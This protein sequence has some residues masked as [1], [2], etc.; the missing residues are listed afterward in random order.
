MFKPESLSKLLIIVDIHEVKG[1]AINLN[2]SFS[3]VLQE[4]PWRSVLWSTQVEKIQ[5]GSYL[6]QLTM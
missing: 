2:D 4:S 3:I 1:Q 5:F 6:D